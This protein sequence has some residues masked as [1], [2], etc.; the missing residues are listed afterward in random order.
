[1]T[2]AVTTTEP[3]EGEARVATVHDTLAANTAAA[4]LGGS[5][6]NRE[7]IKASGKMLVRERLAYLFDDD[8]FIED[9][10]FARFSEGLPGDAV[11]CAYG[12]NDGRE[13]CVIA[14][15]YS[16]K[17][18]TWGYRTFEKITFAQETA[19]AAGIRRRPTANA[20]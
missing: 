10:L 14:N 19:S 15:D 16:V 13:V 7:K 17:A 12:R 1:M 18:G 9:G 6:K 11:V 8:E 3:E 20:S 5:Q 4:K 2:N